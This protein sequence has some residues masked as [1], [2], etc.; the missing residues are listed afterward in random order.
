MCHVVFGVVDS[1][2]VYH[3]T[4]PQFKHR[5]NYFPFL[6][7]IMGSIFTSW[8]LSLVFL[9]FHLLVYYLHVKDWPITPE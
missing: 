4:S 7:N 2:P 3:T 5:Q 9:V 6:S 8:N 1:T